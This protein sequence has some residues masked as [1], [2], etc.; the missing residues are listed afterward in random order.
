MKPYYQNKLGSIYNADCLDLINF[1]DNTG[2]KVDMVLTDPPYGIGENANHNNSR[3]KAAKPTDY[4]E[5]EYLD[6]KLSKTQMHAIKYSANKL[7]IF[8]GNYYGSILGDTSCYI[9]WDK[10]NTGDFADA[11]LAWTNF[12]KATRIVKYTWNGMI[13][14][15]MGDG[16][17]KRYYPTQKPLGLF[18]WILEKYAN[19]NDLILDPCCGSGTTG[20][21]C[22]DL[23]LKYILGDSNEK[24]CE[25]AANRISKQG[26]QLK[27]PG[28][29]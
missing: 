10:N 20:L 4:K 11:E 19:A 1:L 17:E 18:R 27:L 22:E 24:A 25:I 2:V 13:Q 26:I 12:D 7:I 8:G 6:R 16:K 29:K 5:I 21:A 9:V 15:N 3:G 23:G 14:E 28:V